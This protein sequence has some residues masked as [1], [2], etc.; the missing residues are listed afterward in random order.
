[1]PLLLWYNCDILLA[2]LGVKQD[3]INDV[4]GIN[5][6]EFRLHVAT[7]IAVV[8]HCVLSRCV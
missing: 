4:V 5:V 7:R 2:M 8:C 3:Y 6:D 1:M